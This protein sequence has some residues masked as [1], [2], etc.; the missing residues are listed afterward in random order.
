MNDTLPDAIAPH[1][2]RAEALAE[3]VI[4]DLWRP[5]S[6]DVARREAF[7]AA[8]GRVLRY[9]VACA[10]ED[11]RQGV[12]V[13]DGIV[14]VALR[15]V[16]RFD[17]LPKPATLRH[18]LGALA[19]LARELALQGPEP[20][21]ASTLAERL[22]D[23]GDPRAAA[24]R[25]GLLEDADEILSVLA[26]NTDQ[27]VQVTRSD[28]QPCLPLAT[29]LLRNLDAATRWRVQAFAER[30][31]VERSLWT[32]PFGRVLWPLVA[33]PALQPVVAAWLAEPAAPAL[34]LDAPVD[35]GRTERLAADASDAPDLEAPGVIQI[36]TWSLDANVGRVVRARIVAG[37]RGSADAIGRVAEHAVQ[38]AYVA[39]SACLRHGAPP[40]LKDHAIRFDGRIALDGESLGLPLAIAFYSCWTGQ[41]LRRG[42][43]ATGRVDA[44]T[45]AVRSVSL[46]TLGPKLAAW[47]DQFGETEAIAVV[48]ARQ[49]SGR[50]RVL[51]VDSL[52]GALACVGLEQ[53][54]VLGSF[55]P[56]D[57]RTRLLELHDLTMT[58]GLGS[59]PGASW[60]SIAT[61]L[62]C[63]V[64]SL[65]RD[66]APSDPIAEGRVAAAIA[67]LH[68]GDPDLARATLQR[69][70]PCPP[71]LLLLKDTVDLS[72]SIDR[73]ANSQDRTGLAQRIRDHLAGGEQFTVSERHRATGTLG[74]ERLHAHDAEAAIPLLTEAVGL[75]PDWE[76][77]RSRIYL[78]QA[79]R[80]R[81]RFD[82]AGRQL[83]TATD[84]L[85]ATRRHDGAYA[86]E[87]EMYL[88]Y[89]RARVALA[90]GDLVR[91]RE[92]I[93]RAY[94]ATTT[95]WWPRLGIVRTRAAIERR[96]GDV[97]RATEALAEAERLASGAPA[98][99]RDLVNLLLAEARG[100][101]V[102][103]PVVY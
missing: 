79:L 30:S 41:G 1:R 78:S 69:I 77:P 4:R 86:D 74:R 76:R 95:F 98:G 13:T 16:A 83:D 14:A 97:D 49:A 5:A 94:D 6:G 89:E 84:E 27:G 53:R 71:R 68:G 37:E 9:E 31:C 87:T 11:H 34:T 63:L 19:R 102:E 65:E 42:T 80:G 62:L 56:P 3:L 15:T 50:G 17:S 43:A 88:D 12:S 29:C 48:P 44:T 70:D 61:R 2:D 7:L 92:A 82:E 33:D 22:V 66:G 24:E 85:K 90:S 47:V 26:V 57:T 32:D 45:G 67:A 96:L 103:P 72:I 59:V 101:T 21:P 99:H 35:E 25:V 23:H 54:D 64:D 55:A 46:T 40:P 28:L 52:V 10:R 91:A 38:A 81:G 8:A 18:Q 100:E 58:R 75:A 20:E 73:A 36:L 39:A 60:P 93:R 51:G